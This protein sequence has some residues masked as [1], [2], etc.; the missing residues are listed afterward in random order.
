MFD[1]I[2]NVNETE[3]N[4]GELTDKYPK[5]PPKHGIWHQKSQKNFRGWHSRT[6]SAGGGDSLPHP[7]PARLHAVRGGASSHVAGT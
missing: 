2:S 7:P 3:N 1:E 6:P 4:S 5:L